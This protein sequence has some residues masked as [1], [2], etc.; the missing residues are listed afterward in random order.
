MRKLEQIVAQSSGTAEVILGSDVVF[1]NIGL[2]S[3]LV[4][5]GI[6]TYGG[7]LV[8]DV[9]RIDPKDIAVGPINR[10]TY[11]I[12]SNGIEL[13]LLE[14]HFFRIIKIPAR[15]IPNHHAFTTPS[16]TCKY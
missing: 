9:Y 13:P 8:Y 10:D 7:K 6:S 16:V 4:A 11:W 3:K 12:E 5:T 14:G 1:N 15:F 2:N